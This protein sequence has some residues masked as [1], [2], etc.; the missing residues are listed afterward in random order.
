MTLPSLG[1]VGLGV[2]GAPMTRRLLARGYR[3]TVWNREN[4]RAGE[5]TP[6]GA[7]WAETPA[8]VRGSS[9]IV[10]TCVLDGDAVEAVC[11][12]DGG[13]ASAGS[14]ADLLIDCS[15]VEP[16]RTRDLAARLAEKAGMDWIDAPVS[17]GPPLAEDGKLTILA[18]GGEA[19]FERARP[20]LEALAGT[21]TRLGG[22]GAGQTAKTLNQAIV[23]VNYVLMAELLRLAEEAGV[24]AAALPAALAGGM[25]DSS[26]LQRI[27]PQMQ[28][29]DYDPPK[30]Y[31][32]QLDKDLKALSRFCRGLGLELPVIEA[33]IERYGAYV[34]AGNGMADS[35]AIGRFYAEE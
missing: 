17:G 1:F 3:V 18:G 22:L 7:V 25:A 9:D 31:A 12:G 32:R 19:A 8:Q 13:F 34:S 15:T 5:V 26:I 10:L 20:V 33:A 24:D 27:Y 30:A 4:E 2:M 21:L 29:R 14:G 16:E 11:L 28:R 6:H 23:G 35:A